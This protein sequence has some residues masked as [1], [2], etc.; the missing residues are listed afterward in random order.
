MSILE[1]KSISHDFSELKVLFDVNLEVNEGERHAIIGDRTLFRQAKHLEAARISQDGSVPAHEP[2][3][4][5]QIGH[6]VGTEALAHLEYGP[7]RQRLRRYYGIPRR[8][9]KQCRQADQD[10]Q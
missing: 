4:A 9:K 6:D 10:G 7:D 5:A 2:V 3:K 8:Y 1:T